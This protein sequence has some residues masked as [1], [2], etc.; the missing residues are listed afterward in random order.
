MGSGQLM[1]GPMPYHAEL[2]SEDCPV[3]IRATWSWS[4]DL[5]SEVKHGCNFVDLTIDSVLITPA[6][7]TNQAAL[8]PG[9][10][11]S[12]PPGVDGR[13]ALTR[14]KIP[15]N[16]GRAISFL[17]EHCVGGPTV[18]QSHFKFILA[19]Q[20]GYIVRSDFLEESL[21]GIP[22]SS[23]VQGFVTSGQHCSIAP[24]LA[25]SQGSASHLLALLQSSVG[26]VMARGS[27]ALQGLD[28]ELLNRLSWPWIIDTPVMPS[29]VVM[30]CERRRP[31]MCRNFY[32]A[33]RGCGISVVVMDK[34]GHWMED[35]N[36]LG[37]QYREHFVPFT[38]TGYA[39]KD[40]PQHIADVI[41]GLPYKV[42]GILTTVDVFMPG[43]AR[44]AEILG[45][46]TLGSE[47]YRRGTDKFETR[48][49]SRAPTTIK[50]E[51]LEE[52]PSQL[53]AMPQP[54]EYPLIVKPTRSH[55]SEGVMRVENEAEL[56]QALHFAFAALKKQHDQFGL[57]YHGVPVIVETYCEGPEV[58]VN[59]LLWD[60]ELLHAEVTD[61][62]PCLGDSPEA[63][64]K[65]FGCTGSIFPSAL[66][67][68]EIDMLQRDVLAIVRAV[69]LHSGVIHAEAKVHNSAR[70]V[71]LA[72]KGMYDLRPRSKPVPGRASTF[73]LEINPRPAGLPEAMCSIYAYGVDY[74]AGKLLHAI[75]DEARFRSIAH[76][77]R[78]K[79]SWQYAWLPQAIETSTSGRMPHDLGLEKLGLSNSYAD[80][81]H[82]WKGGEWVPPAKDRPWPGLGFMVFRSFTSRQELLRKIADAREHLRFHLD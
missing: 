1:N 36:G 79:P 6:A 23:V 10:T 44:A 58:D 70:E 38:T 64:S 74:F 48:Q 5:T 56:I 73:L 19:A 30:I 28:H 53:A 62:F 68:D 61:N 7:G 26:V 50:V 69:G 29:R 81:W 25:A 80:H 13:T 34:P 2:R 31:P 16:A 67:S 24:P 63:E 75:G 3:L 45:L 42:D 4:Q 52:F 21:R 49:L 51:S 11:A 9:S 18:D 65:T 17:L 14:V 72:E 59:M 66:P 33:A 41:R 12:A 46:P 22:L 39:L 77:F 71:F 76:G 35:D 32:A 55:G 37:P 8:S 47:A 40:L 78:N 20:D 15:K 27:K 60:G 57:E 82:Y 43:I 54:L